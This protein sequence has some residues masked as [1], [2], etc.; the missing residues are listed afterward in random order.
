MM[1]PLYTKNHRNVC[2]ESIVQHRYFY[3]NLNTTK[4]GLILNLEHVVDH[5]EWQPLPKTNVRQ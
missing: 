3:P 4:F 1:P 5:P 2:D